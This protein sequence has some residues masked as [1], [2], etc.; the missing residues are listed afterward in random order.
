M[1][2]TNPINKKKIE[3]L[4]RHPVSEAN[5]GKKE[6]TFLEIAENFKASFDCRDI[7][8]KARKEAESLT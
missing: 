6:Y 8:I 4:N 7:I 2:D 5:T 3:F 1:P